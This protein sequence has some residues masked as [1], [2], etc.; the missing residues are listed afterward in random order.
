MV[1]PFLSVIGTISL[2]SVQTRTA[3]VF[4][5]THTVWLPTTPLPSFASARTSNQ[6]LAGT[7]APTFTTPFA[8]TLTFSPGDEL[9]PIFQLTPRLLA[10]PG[11]TA[12]FRPKAEEKKVYP[13]VEFDR[14]KAVEN[15]RELVKC[16]TV[17]YYDH[18]LEDESEFEKLIAKMEVL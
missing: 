9:L 11:S 4:G 13:P 16:R 17:S 3:A 12:A 15:L 14:E 1:F 5:M 6:E 7:P 18:S 10:P 8:L 2:S